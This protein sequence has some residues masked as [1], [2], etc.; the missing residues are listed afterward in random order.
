M[1]NRFGEELYRMFFRDYTHKVW[2][3]YPDAIDADWG[4]Q[5]IKGVSIRKALA[6][7]CAVNGWAELLGGLTLL[8][9]ACNTLREHNVFG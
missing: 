5:R 4:S 7:L 9:I 1:V 2:G 8:A 3:R 6:N